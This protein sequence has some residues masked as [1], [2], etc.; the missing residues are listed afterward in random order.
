[1][2]DWIRALHIPLAA[3]RAFFSSERASDV[4]NME[5][6]LLSRNFEDSAISSGIWWRHNTVPSLPRLGTEPGI[7]R[8]FSI[9][10]PFRGCTPELKHK[11]SVRLRG[12]SY[13]KG[14]LNATA[15]QIFDETLQSGPQRRRPLWCSQVGRFYPHA[16]L[17]HEARR[18]RGFFK[19]SKLSKNLV[20]EAEDTDP[21]EPP[22]WIY[23]RRQMLLGCVFALSP[24]GQP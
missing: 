4:Q 23:A 3:S 14:Y 7:L 5:L 10:K 9:S 15:R 8:P 13:D 22:L 6:G 12:S 11:L 2:I 19:S 17:I 1:M 20:S 24:S 16:G 18:G 21:W